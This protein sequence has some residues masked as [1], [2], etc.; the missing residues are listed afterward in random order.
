MIG[1]DRVVGQIADSGKA[2]FHFSSLFIGVSGTEI[3][4]PAA[5]CG[6]LKGKT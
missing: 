4:I 1:K 5:S 6:V 3:K 2:C